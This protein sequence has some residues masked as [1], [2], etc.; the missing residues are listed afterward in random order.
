MDL[1][2]ELVGLL[3]QQLPN[4]AGQRRF[5]SNHLLGGTDVRQGPVQFLHFAVIRGDTGTPNPQCE[6]DDQ[7][8]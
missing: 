8:C 6:S 5:L 4:A 2:F 3:P 1:G 7:R